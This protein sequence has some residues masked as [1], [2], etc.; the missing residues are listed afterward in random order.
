MNYELAPETRYPVPVLQVEEFVSYLDQN[1]EIYPINMENIFIAGDLVG[2]QITSHKS[3]LSG[4]TGSKL[5]VDQGSSFP[6][7]RL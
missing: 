1:R 3:G 6:L 7:C 5:R 2:G 4:E